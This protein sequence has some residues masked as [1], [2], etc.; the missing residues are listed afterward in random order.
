LTHHD[1]DVG[2]S[3]IAN[4]ITE[5]KIEITEEMIRAAAAVLLAD[6]YV[7]PFSLGEGYAER[8][9]GRVLRSALK[10]PADQNSGD[11]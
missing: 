3:R 5:P 1:A 11:R 2:K 9:V 4:A 10:L 7:E 8:L 6:Y